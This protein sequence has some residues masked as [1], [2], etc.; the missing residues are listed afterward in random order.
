[1][2]TGGL[3]PITSL[4]KPAPFTRPKEETKER[5]VMLKLS[6]ETVLQA[7]DAGHVKK[8]RSTEFLGTQKSKAKKP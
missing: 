2:P 3:W 1:M 6:A 4:T 5:T 8:P 7:K